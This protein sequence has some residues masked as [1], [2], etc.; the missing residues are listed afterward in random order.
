[1]KLRGRGEVGK[2]FCTLCD[3]ALLSMRAGRLACLLIATSF[4]ADCKVPSGCLGSDPSCSLLSLLVF[5]KVS[6]PRFLYAT[7][8][9][10]GISQFRFNKDTGAL[11]SLGTATSAGNALKLAIDDYG[12]YAVLV[13]DLT[14]TLQVFRINGSTGLLTMTDTQSNGVISTPFPAVIDSA[15][16]V[17][18]V[19]MN[20]G[21]QIITYSINA[22]GT[23]SNIGSVPTAGSLQALTMH[24]S[25]NYVIAAA[26]NNAYAFRINGN[27]TLTQTGNAAAGNGPSRP[28]ISPNGQFV[29]VSNTTSG[30]ITALSFDSS[31]GSLTLLEHEPT[32]AAIQGAINSTGTIIAATDN[33]NPTT[34]F[35]H[36]IQ[37][38]GF[39]QNTGTL[40]YGTGGSNQAPL[41]A[42]ASNVVYVPLPSLGVVSM[43]TV[44]TSVAPVQTAQIASTGGLANPVLDPT[45]KYVYMPSNANSLIASFKVQPDGQLSFLTTYPASGAVNVTIA[46]F[47]E[48]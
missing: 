11:T 47:F 12:T 36:T 14:N 19:P 46:S 17:V 8:T 35:S 1:M 31:S 16:S 41:F 23:L 40:A 24:P 44:S 18:H 15:H 6:V 27:G 28:V 33:T 9:A 3:I 43:T 29:Y 37:S 7:N 22:S 5:N 42:P 4:F 48:F 2:R 38:N 45:G 21:S 32:A 25:G 34:L 39:L 30:T 26:Q 10:G 13:C 20:G